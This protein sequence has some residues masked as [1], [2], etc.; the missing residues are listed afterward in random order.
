VADLVVPINDYPLPS[1]NEATPDAP[2]A[3]KR[4]KTRTDEQRLIQLLV[5]TIEPAT[6]SEAG[7]PGTIDYFPL[8]MALVINQTPDVHEQV[9]DLLAALRRLQ[10]LQV[11]TE[12]RLVNISG[13]MARRLKRE[14]GV[15]CA[16]HRRHAGQAVA[17]ATFL[18]PGQLEKILEALQA[19]RSTNILQA[20]KLSLFNGQYATL[21]VEDQKVFTTGME[22]KWDGE[23]LRT[24]PK[25]VVY[26]VG[27][28]VGVR[29]VVSA[30]QRFVRLRLQGRLS[31][32]D[33]AVPKST[34]TATR[35]TPSGGEVSTKPVSQEVEQPA[36]NVYQLEANVSVP[37]GGT[38]VL[39]GWSYSGARAGQDGS[40]TEPQY[41]LM[42]ATS[43]ILVNSSDESDSERL[44]TG[45]VSVDGVRK[46][47]EKVRDLLAQYQQA[48]H[49]RRF[50]EAK[51][52]AAEA[53]SL[54]PGCFSRGR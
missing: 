39:S 16:E 18:E 13:A 33:P 36:L 40:G 20:P 9:A 10:D 49:E 47:Q 44:Q 12:L 37:D 48:C 22:V 25:A 27:L 7:G 24:T 8:G 2:A 43:H 42:L 21:Q 35:V 17:R 46:K 54:D 5:S 38:A 3:P 11:A 53:L 1:P 4:A 41:L 51:Q 50:A 32:L 45:A 34:V 52:L 19:D 6:W 30:D 31:E 28:R 23:Q 29:A 26:P 15:D 14:F